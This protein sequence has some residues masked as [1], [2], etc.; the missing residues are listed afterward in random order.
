MD[1]YGN[2]IKGW[3]LDKKVTLAIIVTLIMQTA[4]SVWWASRINYTVGDH[5]KRIS[6]NTANISSNTSQNAAV[7]ETLAA[8]RE[9]QKYQ[10]DMLKDLQKEMRR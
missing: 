3:H 1:D 6:G 9:G 8:I 5:E 7:R 2:E 10:T 4:S